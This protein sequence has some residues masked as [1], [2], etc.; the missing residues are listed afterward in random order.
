MSKYLFPLVVVLAAAM[1]PSLV[2]AQQSARNADTSI[3]DNQT[4]FEFQ[5]EQ[6]VR[7]R[8]G[9]PPVYPAR[10]R[11]AR[12]EGQVLVQYV[13]D[14]RGS[15]QMETFKVLKSNDDQFTQAV[16]Y[17]VANMSFYHAEHQGKPVKQLVQQPFTFAINK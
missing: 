8:A 9:P 15:A 7:F 12:V 17:A 2:Q 4:F 3:V 11:A 14:E 6:P 16:K 1:H 10:L 5:V 13:V